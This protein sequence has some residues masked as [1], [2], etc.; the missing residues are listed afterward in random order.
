M[1]STGGAICFFPQR[2][3]IYRAGGHRVTGPLADSWA[4]LKF[5]EPLEIRRLQ[6]RPSRFPWVFVRQLLQSTTMRGQYL[7]RG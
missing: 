2:A 5:M 3:F 4:T 7:G 6:L 1:S